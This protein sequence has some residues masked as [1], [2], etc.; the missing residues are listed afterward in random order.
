MDELAA[1]LGALGCCFNT[2]SRHRRLNLPASSVCRGMLA[3]FVAG[4]W[5]EHDVRARRGWPLMRRRRALLLESDL[6]TPA[7]RRSLPIYNTFFHDLDLVPFAGIGLSID[8]EPWTLNVIRS[9]SM[10]WFDG[11]AQQ[12]IALQPALNRLLGF[13]HRL[14]AAA[15]DG[16]LRAFEYAPVAAVALDPLGKVAGANRL[17]DRL[18]GDG[19]DVRGGQLTASDPASNRALKELIASA[20]AGRFGAYATPVHVRRAG[21]PLVVE[22]IPLDDKRADSFG[23]AGTLLLVRDLGANAPLN[24]EA[25]RQVYGLTPRELDVTLLLSEGLSTRQI[26][27]RLALRT[28]SVQQVVKVILAKTGASDQ[29]ALMLKL[30]RLPARLDTTSWEC[31][32]SRRRAQ[33]QYQS[34]DRARDRNAA[35]LDERIPSLEGLTPRLSEN[36][37]GYDFGR[38]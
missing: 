29:K 32:A 3:E 2:S 13:A 15:R 36:D 19:L 21:E 18:F 33:K 30:S 35:L 22:A 25:A 9:E 14:S 24:G 28:S 10:G 20:Q 34:N 17:A 6:S 12:L 1:A 16:M 26:A 5:A 37:L 27:E 31:W 11:E 7:E 4:G 23:M 38:R 8:G